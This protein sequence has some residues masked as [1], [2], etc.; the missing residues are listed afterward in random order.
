M[1]PFTRCRSFSGG[2]T[3]VDSNPPVLTLYDTMYIPFGDPRSRAGIFDHGQKLI[4]QSWYFRGA[5]P[6]EEDR[7]IWTPYSL[8]EMSLVVEDSDCVYGGW[9]H[10][11]YGHFILSSLSRFW[12]HRL[13][14]PSTKV[15][16]HSLKPLEH[17]FKQAWFIAIIDAL[18][19][20][21]SQLLRLDQPTRF[22]S[23]I[24]AGPA[25][26]EECFAHKVFARSMNDLGKRITA[27]SKIA[28]LDNTPVYFS[29]VRLD[30]G[31]QK[32][33]NESDICDILERNG[34]RIVFPEAMS[35]L[36]QVT[37]WYSER[38][39]IS[40][41]GSS[42]YTSIFA[43]GKDI[44][45]IS[46]TSTI[47]SSYSLIDTIN[48]ARTIYLSLNTNIVNNMGAGN[49]FHTNFRITDPAK[50][51]ECILRIVD[52]KERARAN[53]AHVPVWPRNGF[54]RPNDTDKSENGLVNL[55]LRCI[56]NQSSVHPWTTREA[57]ETTNGSLSGD[58]NFHT[59][60]EFGAWWEVDLLQEAYIHRIR[61]F[62]R[63][64]DQQDQ[65][66][67]FLITVRDYDG[68]TV[69]S[70]RQDNPISFGGV[71][72]DP[73]V[74]ILSSPVMGR[75]VRIEILTKGYLHL[76]Q[77]EVLGTMTQTGMAD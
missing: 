49:G 28:D 41:M 1:T 64:D 16:V 42:L 51:G 61:V 33:Y 10:E 12:N 66:S 37:L 39:F 29:K 76:E 5:I 44:L 22:R 30:S 70:H 9:L 14:N 25:F 7:N 31:V 23:L 68:L 3:V 59:E 72:A 32:I 19:I 27:E 24:L 69:A 50:V 71:D 40:F 62:N 56:G 55:A 47:P 35:L 20:D 65:C 63:S 48:E 45:N 4:L 67:R 17:W 11:H 53:A 8:K 77:V 74:W 52:M 21:R 54:W 18:G 34:V 2:S 36:E 13:I 58:F 15:V 57:G 60:L 6:S 43:P 73:F 26:Q 46:P 38:T 75:I